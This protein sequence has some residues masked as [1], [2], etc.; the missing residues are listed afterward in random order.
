MQKLTGLVW[1][2]LC[3]LNTVDNGFDLKEMRFK[4]DDG[5]GEVSTSLSSFVTT[6]RIV[7]YSVKITC[8]SSDRGVIAWW[9]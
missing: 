8:R 6:L 2:G 3:K 5:S 9:S 7:G 4:Q 1:S